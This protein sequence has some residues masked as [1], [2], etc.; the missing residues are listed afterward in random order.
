MRVFD[1]MRVG[2]SRCVQ[3]NSVKV[4]PSLF[5]H[6]STIGR[7]LRADVYAIKMRKCGRA[8][9]H[10]RFFNLKLILRTVG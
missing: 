4:Y 7:Q 1:V 5:F 9:Y 10:E 2:H 3:V 8:A 6:L